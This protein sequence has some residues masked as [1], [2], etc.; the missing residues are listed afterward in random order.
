M[1]LP[2]SSDAIKLKCSYTIRPL[3]SSFLFPIS[4]PGR[5]R[6]VGLHSLTEV[7]GEVP[8]SGVIWRMLAKV[9]KPD[10]LGHVLWDWPA[11]VL[12]VVGPAQRSSGL[13]SLLGLNVSSGQN[14]VPGSAASASPGNL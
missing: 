13:A 4:D 5:I 1:A 7:G 3:F 10:V 2:L 8:F 6:N 11:C 9:G 12:K 14:V